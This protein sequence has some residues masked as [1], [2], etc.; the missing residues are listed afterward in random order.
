MARTLGATEWN[1]HEAKEVAQALHHKK[2]VTPSDQDVIELAERLGRAPRSIARIFREVRTGKSRLFETAAGRRELRKYVVNGHM[3]KGRT[4]SDRVK[5]A[6]A[7]Y[8]SD[9]QQVPMSKVKEMMKSSAKD[10]EQMIQIAYAWGY[11]KAVSDA[12][13]LRK[14]VPDGANNSLAMQVSKILRH[15]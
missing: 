15:G 5:D 10:Y 4:L 12:S 9:E 8:R 2:K 7:S 6:I 13:R 1:V 14:I 3:N 11:N